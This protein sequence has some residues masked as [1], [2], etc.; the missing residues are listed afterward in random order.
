MNSRPHAK[1][2][3][4][5]YCQSVLHG[6]GFEEHRHCALRLVPTPPRSRATGATS[7]VNRCWRRLIRAGVPIVQATKSIVQTWE[8]H[9]DNWGR[10]KYRLLPWL[11]PALAALVDDFCAEGLLNQTFVVVLGEFGRSPK[12]PTLPGETIPAG[13][14]F[15]AVRER[16]CGR[17]SGHR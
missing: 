3:R 12:V 8:T 6:Q 15:W 5:P 13:G 17:W 9:V 7:A 10:L 11:D 14:L 4:D 1:G 16:R 2:G